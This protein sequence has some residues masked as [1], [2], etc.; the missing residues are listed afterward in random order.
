MWS[1][2][3]S[4]RVARHFCCIVETNWTV[5]RFRVRPLPIQL[6]VFFSSRP[7][8]LPQTSHASPRTEAQNVLV[9]IVTANRGV[10]DF[11][12]GVLDATVVVR[13][14]VLDATIH[15]YRRDLKKHDGGRSGNAMV[16]SE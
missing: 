10:A 3:G 12:W 4:L 6:E 11:Q 5:T 7:T 14:E 15:S 2:A 16:G 8:Q 1:L 13:W 9:P